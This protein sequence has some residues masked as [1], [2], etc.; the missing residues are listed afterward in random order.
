MVGMAVVV[1]ESFSFGESCEMEVVMGSER[2]RREGREIGAMLLH[3][4]RGG[5]AMSWR[6]LSLVR[7]L[8]DRVTSST[9]LLAHTSIT[10]L[11]RSR[12]DLLTLNSESTS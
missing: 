1:L 6:F 7:R 11:P 5:R 10:K 12:S 3:R 8:L 9:S 4:S 2:E